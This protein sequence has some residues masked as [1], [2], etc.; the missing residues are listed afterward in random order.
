MILA[1]A[2]DVPFSATPEGE[3]AEA[4][5]HRFDPSNRSRRVAADNI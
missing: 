5:V 1:Y 3:E 2:L 4:L